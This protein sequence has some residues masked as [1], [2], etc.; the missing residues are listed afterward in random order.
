MKHFHTTNPK[1][2]LEKEIVAQELLIK[3]M[4]IIS[5]EKVDKY[6]NFSG[7][8]RQ[9]KELFEALTDHSKQLVSEKKYLVKL[10]KQLDNLA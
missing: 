4:E 2:K 9:E 8:F 6:V 1:A 5:K 10:K 7:S 3:D